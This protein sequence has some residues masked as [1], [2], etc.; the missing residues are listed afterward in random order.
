VCAAAAIRGL[1]AFSQRDHFIAAL[2]TLL[3]AAAA[4]ALWS[5]THIDERI[6]DHDVFWIA[7]IGTLLLALAADSLVSLLWRS[8]SSQLAPALALILTIV[9]AA[10]SARYV[11]QVVASSF[12][13][14]AEAQRAGEL[15]ADLEAYM[16]RERIAR[17]LIKIDQDAWPFAA[18]AILALQ[19]QGMATAVEDDWIVMFTPAFRATGREDAVVTVAAPAEHL[20]LRD[21]GARLISAH[22]PVYAYAEAVR[23]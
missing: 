1:I 3:L 9:A 20:R 21:R 10:A 15:A 12:H 11:A 16:R 4:I 22:D 13:P 23:R 19:K 14:P 6:F 18:G 2:S 7:G 5:A 8:G 17:P